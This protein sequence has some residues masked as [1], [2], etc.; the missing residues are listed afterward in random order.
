MIEYYL[1]EQFVAFA[2]C[3]TLLGASEKVHVSQPALSRS[4]RKIEDEF[5]VSLFNRENSKI[6]L[7]E[8]G[9]VAAEYARRA[10]DSN[11]DMIERVVSFDRSLRSVSV[12]SC[13]PFPVNEIMPVLQEHLGGKTISV[14]INSD[15]HLVSGLKNHLYQIA[16]L[17]ENPDDKSLFCQRFLE[18]KLYI[19]LPKE[20]PLAK[21]KSATWD[22]LKNLRILMD[23]TSGFWKDIAQSHLPPENLLVQNSFDALDELVEASALPVFNSDQFLKKGYEPSGRVSVPVEGKDAHAVYYLAALNAEQQKFRSIFNAVRGTAISG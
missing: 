5:G 8:T 19:S 2:E 15:A 23:G 10:L 14:E 3:G 9:K 18:E 7:N 12:G 21:K 20:N 16:I 1:L 4:M 6:S 22:D 13:A 11:R 17:H